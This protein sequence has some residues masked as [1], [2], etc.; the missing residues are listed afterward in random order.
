MNTTLQLRD[1]TPEDLPAIQAI[2]AQHVLHGSAS[3]EVE[4]PDV[5]ELGRRLAAVRQAG[6]PY[7]VAELEGEVVGYAYAV[8]YRPRPAYRH[9]AEDSVYVRDG[10]GGR[11]I[12]QRLLAEV[13][14]GCTAAGFR[15]LVAV[16]GDS[17]NQASIALHRRLGFRPVG[18]FEAVGFKHGRWLDSVLMQLS[19]GEGDST[20]GSR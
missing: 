13:I 20:P 19:L 4:P 11:G 5:A 16:I 18:T 17:A 7:R 3:F 6:L 2:Y 12:G 14:E 8:L 10:L 1:A 15:Q 9:T